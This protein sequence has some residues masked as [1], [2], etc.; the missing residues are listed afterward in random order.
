MI[1]SGCRNQLHK[2]MIEFDIN[3]GLRLSELL[4]L[5][6]DEVDLENRCLHI[7]HQLSG[8]KNA[9]EEYYLTETK[10]K[11]ERIV[12]LNDRAFLILKRNIKKRKGELKQNKFR[13]YK[14]EISDQLIFVNRQGEYFTRLGFYSILSYIIKHAV[15][16]GYE[17]DCSNI[18]P[19]TFRHT[20]ATRCME[21]GM[22]PNSVS[23]LLGHTTIRTT[24]NYI[25]NTKDQFD[26][27]IKLIN[28]I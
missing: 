9:K 22:T 27:D 13:R 3:T 12:P 26:E 6:F 25:H 23:V 15:D 24:I 4:A 17:F 20:F 7:R 28:N 14:S 8:K 2:D 19:H 16:E 5:T 21:A 1:Y 11:K 10:T 18:S